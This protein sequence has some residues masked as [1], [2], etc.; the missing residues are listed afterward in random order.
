VQL[1]LLDEG[2]SLFLAINT[3]QCDQN[4]PLKAFPING[5]K[6]RVLRVRYDFRVHI[7]FGSERN[8]NEYPK[9]TQK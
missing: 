7:N 6:R 5:S 2:D 3:I 4:H 8:L 1:V 9:K